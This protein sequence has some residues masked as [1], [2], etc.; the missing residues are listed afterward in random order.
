MHNNEELQKL[1]HSAAHLVA[2]AITELYPDTQLT[3]GPA[4]ATGFFYDILPKENLKEADIASIEQR[5]QEIVKRNLPLSH[6]D[7]EKS[8]AKELY[9]NNPFKLEL[10]D[11]IESDTVGIAQQGEFYDLCRGGHVASTGLLKYVKLTGLSGSYWRADKNGQALQRIS[12]VVFFT[13][14][15][16]KAYEQKLEDA[17]KYDHRR[18]GKQLDLFSFHDEGIGFP[19]FHPKGKTIINGLKNYMRKRLTQANYSEIETPSLLNDELWRNSGH[20]AFYKDNMYFSVI[21]EKSYALKPMNCPGA[22]LVFKERPRSYRELPLRLN[23]FGKVHRHE[24]SGVLHGL[25]RVRSFTIDDTHIIC[26]VEQIQD[27]I[28]ANIKILMETMHKFGFDNVSIGLSTKPAN[29]MGDEA[30][31]E[32]ATNGL[33]S[34][35]KAAKLDYKLQEG[36]GAFYGPKLEFVIKDSMEREWQCGTIQIDFFQPENFDLNYVS[37]GGTLKRPVIIHQAMYGSLERFLGIL[38]EHHKGLLPF[39]ISPVQIK[40]LTITD[41]QKEY[42]QD[43]TNMLKMH[44]VRVELDNSSSPLSAQI[45]D[46]QTEKIPWMIVIGK[47]EMEANTITLRYHNGKQELNV[48]HEQLLEK[49]K[50]AL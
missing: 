16:L 46:A 4:T 40:V 5:M 28:L 49:I 6:S 35:L 45:K 38:L 23:E 21:D 29:A 34:A 33:I 2:H 15:D 26:T 19:F 41:E 11:G 30:T 10:I 14:N 9:K 17:Q 43:I 39:W 31:W 32:K 3:I 12:G 13:E 47:K 1:R 50:A 37:S 18:L 48:T 24:L 25:F 7:M 44:G 36:E 27:E 8:K 22:I 42:A 20:Y